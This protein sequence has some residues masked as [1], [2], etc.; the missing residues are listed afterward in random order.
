MNGKT[1]LNDRIDAFGGHLDLS[2]EAIVLGRNNKF[3]ASYAYGSGSKSAANGISAAKEFRNPNNYSSLFGDMSVVGDLSGVTVNRPIFSP[4]TGLSLGMI[5][6][7]ASG[8]QIYTLGW[9]VDITREVN[10]SATGHYFLANYVANFGGDLFSRRLGLESDFT[11]TWNMADGLALIAG[12]DRFFT[13]GY[14]RDVAWS[15]KD[16]DYG[17][18][19][20]QFDLSMSKRGLKP[21][22]G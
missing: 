20:V 5:G 12:Y 18:L 7:H 9:G 8:L 10:F 15:R 13:G 3:F 17:Y 2:A 1:G 16:I 6:I 11:L 22:K 14:F 4:L 21:A 19:M